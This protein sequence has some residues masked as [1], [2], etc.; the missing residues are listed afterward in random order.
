MFLK[1]IPN[2]YNCPP[3]LKPTTHRETIME[4]ISDQNNVGDFILSEIIS[5]Q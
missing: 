1:S 3:F 4:I 2:V 5:F